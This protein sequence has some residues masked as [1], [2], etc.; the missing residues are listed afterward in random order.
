MT[1][2]HMLRY[3]FSYYNFV[4]KY[5]GDFTCVGI[6]MVERKMRKKKERY[7]EAAD[8]MEY[9]SLGGGILPQEV[10]F[11]SVRLPNSLGLKMG[12]VCF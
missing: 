5:V 9:L 10:N 1:H 4:F 8:G 2:T 3:S 11:Q 7:S 6:M 12:S